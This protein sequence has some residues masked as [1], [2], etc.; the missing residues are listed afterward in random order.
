MAEIQECDALRYKIRGVVC[1][2]TLRVDSVADEFGSCQKHELRLSVG[3][4]SLLSAE[5]LTVLKANS[6]LMIFLKSIVVL[7]CT[8]PL[9]HVNILRE[10]P[11]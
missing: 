5:I 2:S 1:R 9:W 7:T 3:L 10:Y 11:D 4:S 8:A 6:H